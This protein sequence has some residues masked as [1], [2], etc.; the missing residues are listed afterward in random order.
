MSSN[1]KGTF[2]YD[3]GLSLCKTNSCTTQPSYGS[4]HAS[5]NL[6]PWVTTHLVR[7]LLLPFPLGNLWLSTP[8][9]IPS[10]IKFVGIASSP[11]SFFYLLLLSLLSFSN[12]EENVMHTILLTS[13]T[14]IFL[15]S[16]PIQ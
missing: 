7:K 13:S 4:L 9:S 14:F 6:P 1:P 10:V 5:L 15:L 12:K 8:Q 16:I 3:R 11:P 2:N